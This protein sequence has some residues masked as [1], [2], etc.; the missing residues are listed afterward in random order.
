MSQT[1][2]RIDQ[3]Y[4]I[5]KFTAIQKHAV[6]LHELVFPYMTFII[7][8]YFTTCNQTSTTT[9]SSE[10]FVTWTCRGLENDLSE[11]EKFRS[12]IHMKCFL[13]IVLF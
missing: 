8:F 13:N 5:L 3:G 10:T 12:I 1:S 6:C 2:S 11:V 4:A 7:P 9:F